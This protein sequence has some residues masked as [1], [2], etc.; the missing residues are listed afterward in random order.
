[1][2]KFHLIA[3][4]LN[5]HLLNKL[6]QL[7]EKNNNKTN[8]K[9]II[10]II[11]IFLILKENMHLIYYATVLKIFIREKICYKKYSKKV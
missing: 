7:V 6:F 3:I 1:M 8:N 4:G 2:F 9:T 10:Y 11:I 5:Y